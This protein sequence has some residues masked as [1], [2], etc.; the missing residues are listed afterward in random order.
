VA[1]HTTC[2]ANGHAIARPAAQG[3]QGH[4]DDD[5]KQAHGG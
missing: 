3:Q 4:K 1:R 5:H 2:H